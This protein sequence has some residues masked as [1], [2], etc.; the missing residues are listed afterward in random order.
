MNIK[1][2]LTISFIAAQAT[3]NFA[4]QEKMTSE[5]TEEKS[6]VG[7]IVADEKGINEYRKKEYKLLNERGFPK[8]AELFK[9]MSHYWIDD[10]LLNEKDRPF[11][12][13]FQLVE[14]SLIVAEYCKN[15]AVC[16][17]LGQK[18]NLCDGLDKRQLEIM[19]FAG[20]IHDCGKA[21]VGSKP[22]S[23]K[24]DI[25]KID[26]DKIK[27]ISKYD[28]EMIGFNFILGFKKYKTVND[29]SFNFNELCKE[30]GLNDNEKKI[31]AIL[32]GSHKWFDDVYA[33]DLFAQPREGTK[34][35]K[36]ER[37]I[38]NI[39]EL[40]KKAKL[41]KELQNEDLIRMA[42]ILT[43]ADNFAVLFD[44]EK[45]SDFGFPPAR[46]PFAKPGWLKSKPNDSELDVR[47]SY[48]KKILYG[49]PKIE[50]N[51]KGAI[52]IIDEMMEL[53]K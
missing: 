3:C 49:D 37:F 48:Y 40:A 24:R 45:Q 19:F 34:I 44:C 26:E 17:I 18:R 9:D 46:R 27:F 50:R 33:R 23:F 42:C 14:H 53:I 41:P 13:R 43:L 12:H 47:I 2:I 39:F 5:Q 31:V 35:V 30:L 4:M 16:P 52:A 28:H 36:P 8:L 51:K 7:K 38:E 25:F 11:I 10:N 22:Q 29:T 32:V 1:K 15:G 21:G 6:I 20:L